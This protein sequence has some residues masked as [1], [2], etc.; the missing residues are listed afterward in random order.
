M[1]SNI[2]FGK[3][4]I[5]VIMVPMD[6]IEPGNARTPARAVGE[7]RPDTCAE[8]GGGSCPGN[9]AAKASSVGIGDNPLKSL[10][11]RKERDLDFLAPD[12]DFLAPGLEF[13]APG[14]EFL[15]P[16]LEAL[17]CGPEGRPRPGPFCL[18]GSEASER[19]GQFLGNR[20][21]SRGDYGGLGAR[22]LTI[23]ARWG[24]C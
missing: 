21:K 22:A 15:L 6:A 19:K 14:L 9:G 18:G 20:G 1:A 2:G 11:S 23:S 8:F 17:P 12:L 5:F 4:E 7:A 13:L 24:I 16:G 3:I 10:N